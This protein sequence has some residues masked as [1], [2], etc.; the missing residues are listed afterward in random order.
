MDICEFKIILYLFEK[1]I[2]Q[3]YKKIKWHT[4][5]SF[6]N[7]I[8][9]RDQDSGLQTSLYLMQIFLVVEPFNLFIL[10]LLFLLTYQL[11][12]TDTGSNIII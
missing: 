11:Y 5:C 10:D 6:L 12:E 8:L 4:S 9:L 3:K 1:N 7:D 2:Y